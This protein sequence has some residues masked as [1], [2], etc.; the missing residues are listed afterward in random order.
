MDFETLFIFLQ[1]CLFHH[2]KH[3]KNVY[4][5]IKKADYFH[6][7]QSYNTHLYF[8]RHYQVPKQTINKCFSACHVCLALCT[9]AGISAALCRNS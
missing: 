3:L 4:S 5:T 6:T 9:A 1:I 2:L 8:T 7:V